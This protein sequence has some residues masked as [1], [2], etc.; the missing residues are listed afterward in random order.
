M[1][2][3]DMLDTLP[4][5]KIQMNAYDE[6]L[7]NVIFKEKQT[8]ISKI[9]NGSKD[10]ILLYVLFVLFSTDTLDSVI[11]RFIIKINS[12][13]RLIFFKGLMFIVLYFVI[14]NIHFARKK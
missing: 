12:P 11:D 5:D 7:S 2:N 4:V 13:E 14:T 10:L 1:Q 3:G 8:A 6:Q 9:V